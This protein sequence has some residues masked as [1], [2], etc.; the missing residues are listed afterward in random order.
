MAKKQKVERTKG[1]ENKYIGQLDKADFLLLTSNIY[2]FTNLSLKDINI[3]RNLDT[4]K[5]IVE[6]LERNGDAKESTVAY[7]YLYSNYNIPVGLSGMRPDEFDSK[8]IK[9]EFYSF[10]LRK[11]GKAYLVDLMVNKYKVDATLLGYILG[12]E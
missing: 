3:V 10:M 9:R 7:S 5:V 1:L 8:R 6:V 12:S 2:N 11:F 4:N